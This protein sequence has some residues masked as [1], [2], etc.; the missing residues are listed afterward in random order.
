MNNMEKTKL[1]HM[2]RDLC[3]AY[4]LEVSTKYYNV[5]TNTVHLEASDKGKG[6]WQVMLT[7]L[8]GKSH[9]D[10]NLHKQDEILVVSRM[11]EME[12]ATGIETFSCVDP[13][14]ENGKLLYECDHPYLF[15]G[16]FDFTKDPYVSQLRSPFVRR[17]KTSR[18]TWLEHQDSQPAL[19]TKH[20]LSIRLEETSPAIIA[21]F[22]ISRFLAHSPQFGSK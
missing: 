16:T 12:K 21:D 4:K 22:F 13:E 8:R 1:E 9:Y 17:L 6:S 10:T 18:D 7:Y 11:V 19:Q 3:R 20:Q 5:N 14:R 2:A 15:E